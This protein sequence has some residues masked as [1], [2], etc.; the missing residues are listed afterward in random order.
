LMKLKNVNDVQI[1]NHLDDLGNG[2]VEVN[3]RLDGNLNVSI[4]KNINGSEIDRDKEI[5]ENQIFS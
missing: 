3:N 2:Q 4:S 5:L 1:N